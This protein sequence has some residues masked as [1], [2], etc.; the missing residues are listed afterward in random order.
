MK[1]KSLLSALIFILFSINLYSQN[2]PVTNIG[3][4]IAC[5]GS[6][7]TVPVSISGSPTL[8]A[9]S[10]RID[11]DGSVLSY[12]DPPQNINP[13]LLA[14]SS[15]YGVQNTVSGNNKKLIL[16][17][18]DVTGTGVL[19]STSGTGLLCELRFHYYGGSTQLS[20][21]NS[22]GMG[23][24]CEYG[25][26]FGNAL[27]DSP[28]STYY[29]DGSV[30]MGLPADQPDTII[31]NLI[32]CQGTNATFS[33]SSSFGVTYNWTN[34]CNF[35]EQS[36]TNSIT[37]NV[38]VSSI[39]GLV[40]V[41]PTNACGTGIPKS[42]YLTVNEPSIEG[43]SAV[44]SVPL[45]CL[46]NPTILT[47]NGGYLG[48]GAIWNWYSEY[49]GGTWIGTG[50]SLAQSPTITG[51]YYVRA[52]GYCN[53]TIC[54]S[55]T[56]VM[57]YPP[58]QPGNIFGSINP[59]ENS[60]S[61]YYVISEQGV[62]YT[63]T[64]PASWSGTST[65]NSAT[66]T[67]GS[68]PGYI[69]VYGTN[70]CGDGPADSIYVNVGY[71]VPQKPDSIIGNLVSCRGSQQTYSVT[72]VTGVTYYWSLPSTWSGTSTSNYIIATVGD[73]AGNIIVIPGNG[74]GYGQASAIYVSSDFSIPS[75]P[76]QI[77][78]NDFVYWGSSSK[79][80]VNSVQGVSYTWFGP[81]DWV[82]TS[83]TNEITYVV[84]YDLGTIT[85]TPSNTCG[86][87]QPSTF[88]ILGSSNNINDI[89]NG[90][91]LSLTNYP[92]PLSDYSTIE[93]NIPQQGE[94]TFEFYNVLGENIFN[95]EEGNKLKGN[96]Y[97]NLDAKRLNSGV[98]T[99]KIILNSGN[100]IYTK[101]IRLVVNK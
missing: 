66:F 84:G 74:C 71:S 76:G 43:D 20:F 72:N 56:V 46:G 27:N 94:V 85:V 58:S 96:Y 1:N 57:N 9:I 35:I 41:T 28:A 54:V 61:N 19:P 30:S 97:F 8:G 26:S 83:T 52:E 65:S 29:I 91:I 63:W 75:N 18:L 7:I 10:L 77:F 99:C 45:L 22:S 49:C 40:T 13:D 95:I 101:A 3:S 31:G 55:V 33:I 51:V 79:Y 60:L 98:Y 87:G 90:E 82:G 81:N 15:V 11:Y 89:N 69:N 12:I 93:Y 42:I 37:Y 44:S 5:P 25:D 2:A 53:T 92:N 78:G 6:I 64:P 100:N 21:N 70:V 50:S 38:D 68:D 4:A 34:T 80:Y 47:V 88:N 59:C 24:D 86:Y 23:G 17:W 67:I 39:S 36:L 48:T 73:I 32:A 62:T 14:V 16:S